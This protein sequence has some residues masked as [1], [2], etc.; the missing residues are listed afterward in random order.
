IDAALAKV[1]ANL[2][3][4]P[5]LLYDRMRWRVRKKQEKAA[6]ETLL[7]PPADLVRPD[8]WWNEREI[9]ARRAVND[10]RMSEAYKIVRDHRMPSGADLLEAEFLAG[11]IALRFTNDPKQALT[12]FTKLYDTARFPV[13]KARGAYWAGRAAAAAKD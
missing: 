7:R 9:L 2:V 10:G 13:T 6:L 12:H 5:G 4:D 11:W 3:N 1:P 8:I